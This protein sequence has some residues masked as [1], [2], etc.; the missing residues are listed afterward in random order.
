M[1]ENVRRLWEYLHENSETTPVYRSALEALE[2]SLSPDEVSS[3]VREAT[4]TAYATR[5]EVP[6][7][8]S[9]AVAT[10]IGEIAATQ[11]PKSILDPVCGTGILLSTVADSTGATVVHGVEIDENIARAAEVLLGGGAS[12]WVGDSLHADLPLGASYDLIVAEPPFG[13]RMTTPVAV[14]GTNTAVGGDFTDVLAA[15]AASKL[16]EVGMA[17]LILPPSFL[18]STRSEQAKNAIADLGCAVTACIHLPS[19]SLQGTGMEAYIAIIER[20]AE[21]EI[22]VGQY[23]AD[24][25]PVSYTHLTLPT[26]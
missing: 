8:S 26:N 17:V 20:S 4:P 18:W 9:P 5:F 14:K 24:L 2:S 21:G 6:H 19:E 7:L 15:W 1:N 23:T 10:F 22:F 3:V 12:I 11:K 25:A 16:S 13:V